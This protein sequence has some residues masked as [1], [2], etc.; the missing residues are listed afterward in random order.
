MGENGGEFRRRQEIGA[1]FIFQITVHQLNL[2]FAPFNLEI[3][4]KS[5][6][7]PELSLIQRD[8]WYRKLKKEIPPGS[9]FSYLL[10]WP[11]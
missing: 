6:K 1:L 8:L 9:P 10:P 5:N 4:Q 11:L 3:F 7:N 2:R